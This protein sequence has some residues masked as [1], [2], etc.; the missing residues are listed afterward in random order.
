M[1]D[2]N[3]NDDDLLN[4]FNTPPPCCCGSVKN[5]SWLED[6]SWTHS[7][8]LCHSVCVIKKKK[9]M[10]PHYLQPHCSIRFLD[11]THSSCLGNMLLTSSGPEDLKAWLSPHIVQAHN[12]KRWRASYCQWHIILSSLFVCAWTCPFPVTHKTPAATLSISP[13]PFGSGG[14]SLRGKLYFF[15]FFL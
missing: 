3:G 2:D 13:D 4:L 12:E 8:A 9:S 11:L 1:Y 10:N 14:F 7:R 5:K 15:F 6:C